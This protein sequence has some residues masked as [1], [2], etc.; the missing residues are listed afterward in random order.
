MSKETTYFKS[1]VFIVNPLVAFLEQF[2]SFIEVM[3]ANRVTDR[4]L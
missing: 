3:N 2:N 1:N 4:N